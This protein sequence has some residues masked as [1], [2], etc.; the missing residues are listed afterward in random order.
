MIQTEARRT[1]KD[2]PIMWR[3]IN[4]IG[5][6]IDCN[7]TYAAKLQYA[8]SEIIGKPIFAH[9]SKKSWEAM[10][11]S[12]TN[13]FETGKVTDQK[14]IFL[15]EDG[16][17]FPGLLQATSIYDH[18]GSLMGSNTVIFDLQE[19]NDEYTSTYMRFIKDANQKISKIGKKDYDNMDRQS[20]SEYDGLKSMF[21]MLAKIDLEKQIFESNHK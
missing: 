1:L 9:V 2:A 12:L 8:K 13:W 21:E 16:T 10:T 11:K 19:I 20:K 18:V 3:R 5:I 6:I 14:I 15:K 7:S 4:S 17:T